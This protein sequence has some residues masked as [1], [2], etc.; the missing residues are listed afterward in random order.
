[1]KKKTCNRRLVMYEIRNLIGNPFIPF[2][3]IVFPTMLL[4]LI[5]KAAAEEAP[6][7]MAAEVNT[8]IFISMSLIVPMAV[9]LLGYSATYS[10]ELEKKIPL[11]MKLFGYSERSTLAARAAAQMIVLTIGLVIYTVIAYAS[12]DMLVP[13]FASAL[14]LIFCIYLVGVIFI[15]LAHGVSNLVRKF[16]PT[17]AIMMLFYFGT[18]ILC[19]MM[20]VKLEQLP[21]ALQ[22]VA[23]LL[24]MSYMSTDFIDFWQKG[25]YNF[26]PMIQAFLFFGAVS[27]IIL[28]ISFR[29]KNV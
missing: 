18:M 24:P 13:R 26:V 20:G 15:I 19:G 7:G 2:F 29:K 5:S 27:G 10:Q 17:Y 16:G 28:M 12:L 6:A 23:R 3:G 4:F 8:A 9:L 21:K 25:S 11:R 1:M 22:T 14:C